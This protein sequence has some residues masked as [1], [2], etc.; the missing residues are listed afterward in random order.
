[1]V[2]PD[3][4][5]YIREQTQDGVPAQDLR[6]ALMESG[7]AERDVDNALH[8]VAA[9]LRPVTEGASIHEDLAQVRGMVAHLASRVRTLEAHLTNVGQVAELPAGT[10]GPERELTVGRTG[11]VIGRVFG[12]FF[13]MA[14][15]AALVFYSIPYVLA[16]PQPQ[17]VVMQ[18][19][20]LAGLFLLLWAYRAMKRGASLMAHLTLILAVG[21]WATVSWYAWRSYHLMEW[22]TALGLG[23]F[24]LVLWGVMRRWIKRYRR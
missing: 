17:W 9:G 3:L 11:S 18:G 20:I 16:H 14:L 5:Q 12:V 21:A 15:L 1:M 13:T 22:S 4:I 8:D 23:V 6:V 7:W 2:S 24:L 10:I 19:T